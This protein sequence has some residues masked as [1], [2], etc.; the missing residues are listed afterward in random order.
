MPRVRNSTATP[1]LS[2]SQTLQ[3]EELSNPYPSPRQSPRVRKY[4]RRNHPRAQAPHTQPNV[5]ANRIREDDAIIISSDEETPISSTSS[6]SHRAQGKRR[7][8]SEN[9]AVHDQPFGS[10]LVN[11]STFTCSERSLLHS[12]QDTVGEANGTDKAIVSPE[13]GKL[14]TLGATI[15]KVRVRGRDEPSLL[16]R[17][18]G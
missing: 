4:G 17:K 5:T 2:T 13:S 10:H 12:Y 8:S 3:I 15:N 1:S 16:I 14:H 18:S 6:N 9:M 7:A 11:I